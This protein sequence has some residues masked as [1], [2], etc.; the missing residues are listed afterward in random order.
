MSSYQSSV[1]DF[2]LLL[3]RSNIWFTGE[4]AT[5][6]QLDLLAILESGHGGV[7]P[8]S[9]FGWDSAV[10]WLTIRPAIRR[11]SVGRSSLGAMLETLCFL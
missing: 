4:T 10:D 1:N 3:V 11:R 5:P 7:R 6:A 8:R 2:K 9:R